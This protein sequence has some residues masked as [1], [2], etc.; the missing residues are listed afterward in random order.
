MEE[1]RKVQARTSPRSAPIYALLTERELEVLRLVGAG[2]S[3]RQIAGKLFI[4]PGTVKVHL[5]NISEK[6]NT[7]GRAGAYA[8]AKELGLL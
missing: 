4:S 7:T 6:L 2:M 5:Y 8:R 1:R 3:N